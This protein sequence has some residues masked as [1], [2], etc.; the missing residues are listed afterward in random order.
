MGLGRRLRELRIG[1]GLTQQQL[2]EPRYTHAYV[3]TIEAG[4]RRPSND[5][6]DYFAAKLDVDVEQLVSGRPRELVASLRLELHDARHAVSAGRLDEAEK[7]FARCEREAKRF[8]LLRLQAK[9]REG[10][11]LVAERR[12]DPE[13]AIGRYEEVEELLS[14]ESPI[15]RVDAIAGK[16]RCLQMLGD[17]RYAC[18]LLESLLEMLERRGLKDPT[19]LVRIHASLVAAY[20]EL[21]LYN[22]AGAAAD[23]ALELAGGAKDTEVVASMHINT[24]RVLLHE[25]RHADAEESLSRAE[26]LYRRLDLLS[27]MGSA[28]LAKGYIFARQ[29]RMSEAREEYLVAIDY[30]QRFPNPVD[31]ANATNE[32]ARLERIE[33]NLESAKDLLE[34]SMKLLGDSDVAELALT[35]R[36]LALCEA[37][38]DP[39]KA[40]KAFR[41]SIE[42]YERAGETVQLPATYR[43]F[44]DFLQA[45]GDTQGGC[46]AYRTGIVALEERLDLAVR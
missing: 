28:H 1:K 34:R 20:F 7:Q 44:G 41:R 9:A 46:E 39:A 8:E 26:D 35:F 21:G 37:R 12:G 38:D 13:T 5:A 29:G 15:A 45:Q 16:A 25:G 24:G 6:L 19:A 30:L 17:T 23:R 43:A 42:L 10:L 2:A 31:E 32:L 11:A 33:G 14:T 4:R 22:K 36:E 27:E 40:E 18:Y 3:S